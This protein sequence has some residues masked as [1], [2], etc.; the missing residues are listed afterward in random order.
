VTRDNEILLP[1]LL[2]LLILLLL[3]LLLLLIIIIIIIIITQLSK[4]SSAPAQIR[5][6]NHLYTCNKL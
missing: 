2:L 3:L 4:I 6:R 1:L 5:P